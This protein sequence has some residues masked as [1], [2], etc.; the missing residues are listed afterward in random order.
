MTGRSDVMKSPRLMPLS[1]T[2]PLLVAVEPDENGG[3]P[4]LFSPDSGT[5]IDASAWDTAGPSLISSSVPATAVAGQA[6]SLQAAF[7]DLWSGPASAPS[8]SFGDGTSGSDCM[9]L[10]KRLKA[11]FSEIAREAEANPQFAARLRQVLEQPV[12]AKPSPKLVQA[13]A[14]KNRRSLAVLDPFEEFKKGEAILRDRLKSLS[15]EQLRDVV[16]QYG[17]DGSKLAMKWKDQ[18]R[19]YDMI[20]ATV[21]SRDRKGDVFL[22]ADGGRQE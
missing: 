3:A 6:I 19:L 18:Q 10:Q 7:A 9:N 21:S 22:T 5:T 1:S 11:L 2:P 14:R 15:L 12:K 17:M 4:V 16:A 8:W 20:V 13:G